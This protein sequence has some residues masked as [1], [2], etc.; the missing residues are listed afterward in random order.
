MIRWFK[1][2]FGRKLFA[3]LFAVTLIMV[4]AGGILTIEGFR[5]RVRS[6]YMAR[7]IAREAR[8]IE[9]VR[10]MLA[11][12]DLAVENIAEDEEFL[13]AIDVRN[14]NRAK[15]K[16]IY[17]RLYRETEQVR[18]YGSVDIYVGKKRHYTSEAE[19]QERDLPLY[20]SVLQEAEDH[21]GQTVYSL[22]YQDATESGSALLVARQISDEGSP[23]FIVIRIRRESIEQLLQEAMGSGEG[24]IL[25]NETLRP[26]CMLGTGR[27]GSDLSLVRSNLMAG[28]NYDDQATDNIY[29]QKLEE[30]GLFLIYITPPPLDPSVIV[31][32]YKIVFLL[33]VIS[34]AVC[35]LLAMLL[36]RSVARPLR[37]ISD[38]MKQFRSG[39]MDVQVTMNREDEFQ[40]LATGFNKTTVQVKEMLREQV[41]S[42]HKLN[43]TRL[44]MMQAQLNPHFLYNTLDTIK[45]VGKANQIPEIA[46]LS[47]NLAKILR[48]SISDKKFVPLS[49]E[50]DLIRNY[51]DIQRIRFDE[52]F[53]LHIDVP[54]ELMDCIIPKLLLQ[55][56]VENAVLHGLE[57][58]RNGHIR[59]EARTAGDEDEILQIFV[60][61]NGKGIS[62]EMIRILE[63]QDEEELSGH[64]GLNHVGTILRI[65]YGRQY[66]L[67]A[68]R[69]EKDG[70]VEGTRMTISLPISREKE[71]SV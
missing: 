40:Q 44:A 39:N 37:I 41:E 62:D 29:F 5:A 46:T 71:Q 12:A 54:A 10:D 24:L 56:I 33:V 55:P 6:D 36:T 18:S 22:D 19:E 34:A 25:T 45:W 60:T 68:S 3:S 65:Y 53:D 61:D 48:G 52:S 30:S 59:I 67:K 31:S 58:Q 4:I 15:D 35:A 32:E 70:V 13:K 47:A 42:E 69:I 27:D 26:F 38:G 51:C 7:D 64:L 1:Q 28:I 11:S 50:L 43:E 14:H 63:E 23:V 8:I 17:N 2:S 49:K 21:K 57:D 16:E 66:G 20:Y 9:K